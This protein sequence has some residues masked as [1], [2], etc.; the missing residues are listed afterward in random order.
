MALKY[1]T[2]DGSTDWA[3]N[4]ITKPSSISEAMSNA[5]AGDHVYIQSGTYSLAAQF[6]PAN[7]GT[8]S[9][10]IIWEGYTT[11]PGD[12]EVAVVT[13]DYAD[14]TV[15]GINEDYHQLRYIRATG[16]GATS[17]RH[18]FSV[19]WTN[20]GIVFLRCFADTNGGDGFRL[21]GD[22][23]AIECEVKGWGANSAA[24]AFYLTNWAYCFGC[25]AHEPNEGKYG[26]A[27]ISSNVRGFDYCIAAA[28]DPT[29][30]GGSSAPWY[31]FYSQIDG[32]AG[33]LLNCT[34]CVADG[35][36]RN[37]AC[38]SLTNAYM[39]LNNCISSN[40]EGDGIYVVA[41]TGANSVVILNGMAHYNNSRNYR[42]TP[43]AQ[44]LEV[45][46]EVQLSSNPFLNISSGDWRVVSGELIGEG[47]AS[48]FMWDNTLTSY[49][50]TP[51]I[52]TVQ[53]SLRR[54]VIG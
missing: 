49:R 40:A 45:I 19:G 15:V 32:S 12:A 9:S 41:G 30:K 1:V 33:G 5:S 44:K 47:G 23:M 48:K 13:F 11:T 21:Q 38:T 14:G 52:G 7:A 50:S 51:T 36:L 18:G 26:F 31:G 42:V 29:E 46:N 39:C 53:S 10:P 4:S 8:I 20:H 27:N 17:G 54:I 25:I 22:A 34:H 24:Y 37:Y 35:F 28:K 6:N 16:N 43:P 2:T 3:S